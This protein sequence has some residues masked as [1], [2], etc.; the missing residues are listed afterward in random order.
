[1]KVINQ[2]SAFG[3]HPAVTACTVSYDAMQAN[4]YFRLYLYSPQICKAEPEQ[5]PV[6]PFAA[7]VVMAHGFARLIF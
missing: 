5:S 2:S 1:M 7:Q 6:S 4:M 3:A